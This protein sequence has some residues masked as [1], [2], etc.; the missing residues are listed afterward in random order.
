MVEC[1][2]CGRDFPDIQVESEEFLDHLA[3]E[4]AN[5]VEGIDERRL[6]KQWDGD[7]AEARGTT[8]EWSAL[9]IASVATA[10]TL[11]C[12]ILIVSLI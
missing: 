11:V 12:G 3:E 5:E 1:E 6:Q 2:Y 9:T 8:Y 7:L 10:A 4:H